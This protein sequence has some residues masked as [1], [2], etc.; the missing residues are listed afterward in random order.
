MNAPA[1]RLGL[2]GFLA[3]VTALASWSAAP[4]AAQTPAPAPLPDAASIV[5]KH[6]AA[7]GG[8]AAFKQVRS[9]H[10]LGTIDIPAQHITGTMELFAARP[11]R[12]HFVVDVPGIGKIEN[13]FDGKVGWSLSLVTG[14][15]VFTGKQLSEAADDA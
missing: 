14:P 12:L 1:K 11:A 15:E 9:M 10:A 3:C 5:A 4:R 13:G 7:L 6:V 2:G 8:A